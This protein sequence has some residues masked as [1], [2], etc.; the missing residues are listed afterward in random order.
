MGVASHGLSEKAG[1]MLLLPDDPGMPRDDG[2]RT[3]DS[4]TDPDGHLVVVKVQNSFPPGV[5]V[6]H[7]IPVAAV[8]DVRFPRDLPVYFPPQ[9]VGWD[10][11][12][13]F[14]VFLLQPVERDLVRRPMRRCV[15]PIE[16]LQ[17]LV[18][19]VIERR[20]GSSEEEI[21][22]DISNG[23]LDLSLCL[24][25]VWFAQSGDEPMVRG[26]ILELRV[27]LVVAGTERPFEDHR[28]DVIV[29]DLL[30]A[31][32][33]V[34]KGMQV[35]LDEGIDV[36]GKGELNMPHPGIP[37]DHAEAVDLAH[38]TVF[39]DPAALSPVYLRLDTGFGLIPKNCLH[40][41]LRSDRADIVFD[42]GV[43]SVK[44]PLLD[45]TADPGGTQRMF[46]DT[47][48]NVLLERIEFTRSCSAG[49][50][51]RHGLCGKVFQYRVSVIPGLS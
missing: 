44:P 4:S 42:D 41:R 22:F 2:M 30:G 7:R 46:A 35:T 8:G 33:E 14:Q 36:S 50:R 13:G 31:A 49:C 45:L 39:F 51:C 6:G 38:A 23:V 43:F 12:Y 5:A 16:P 18:V 25:T 19:H 20:E 24:G 28:F 34:L 27:P 17:E 29:Q 3:D 21:A 15:D 1:E 11:R 32:A 26:K 40:R 37:E 48:L 47:L 9:P 10:R